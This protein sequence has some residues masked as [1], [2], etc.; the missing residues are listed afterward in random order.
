MT[1]SN[2]CHGQLNNRI[3]NS[4]FDLNDIYGLI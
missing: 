2:C 4:D 3:G 1:V